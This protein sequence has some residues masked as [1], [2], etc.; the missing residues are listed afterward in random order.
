M[1]IRLI[2]DL[3][4]HF[5]MNINDEMPILVILRDLLYSGDWRNMKKDFEN[6]SELYEQ[7]E[8]LE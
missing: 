6:I 1:I 2:L 4:D 8:M 7:I 5:T 3:E